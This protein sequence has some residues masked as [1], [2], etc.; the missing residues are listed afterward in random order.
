MI[1]DYMELFTASVLLS[2]PP[3][4]ALL[5]TLFPENASVQF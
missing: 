2:P 3:S 1:P 5:R 4:L